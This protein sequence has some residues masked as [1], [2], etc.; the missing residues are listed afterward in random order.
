MNSQLLNSKEYLQMAVEKALSLDQNLNK[1]DFVV[2]LGQILIFSKTYHDHFETLA[3]VFYC[4][5]ECNLKIG[6]QESYFFM[7][8]A[9]YLGAIVDRDGLSMTEDKKRKIIGFPEPRSTREL[10]SFLGLIGQYKNYCLDTREF[11]YL[12]AELRRRLNDFY[13]NDYYIN[14]FN[15][16]KNLFR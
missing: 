15:R 5:N 3:S 14:I 16:L 6:I 9:E 10:R 11:D 13:L 2:Y 12:A 8:H 7:D 1:N 4:L